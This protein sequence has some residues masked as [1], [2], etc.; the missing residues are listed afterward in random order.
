[1]SLLSRAVLLVGCVGCSMSIVPTYDEKQVVMLPELAGIWRDS[2]DGTDYI[3]RAYDSSYSIRLVEGQAAEPSDFTAVLARDDS[4]TLLLDLMPEDDNVIDAIGGRRE[5]FGAHFNRVHSAFVVDRVSADTIRL[6]TPDADSLMAFMTR[7]HGSLAA[8]RMLAV[9]E[10][11]E[12]QGILRSY[13]NAGGAFST[14]LFRRLPPTANCVS[15]FSQDLTVVGPRVS[16]DG[17]VR[18][19]GLGLKVVDG[20]AVVVGVGGTLP[21]EGFMS[22]A[23]YAFYDSVSSREI[24]HI[25]RGQPFASYVDSKNHYRLEFRW[26][27]VEGDSVTVRVSS[28]PDFIHSSAEAARAEPPRFD[29]E[30]SKWIPTNQQVGRI[31][32][33]FIWSQVPGA[34]EYEFMVCGWRENSDC[35]LRWTVRDTT[36]AYEGRHGVLNNV[37]VRAFTPGIGFGRQSTTLTTRP[38]TR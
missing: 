11:R 28:C 4:G 23:A 20:S 1:M 2:S 10:P 19:H 24:A 18:R 13:R 5:L 32:Q 27:A 34:T 12:L 31:V 21:H 25:T 8:T 36:Y 3:V 22:R 35:H 37:R 7:R 29:Q 9:P 17:A 30:R 16:Y 26:L 6:V 15:D 14:G 33:R 38:P